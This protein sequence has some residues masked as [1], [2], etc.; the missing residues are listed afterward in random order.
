MD[1]NI[2]KAMQAFEI[3]SHRINYLFLLPS[4][5]VAKA[6]G[7]LSMK[8]IMSL[9]YNAVKLGLLGPQD[10]DKRDALRAPSDTSRDQKRAE[11]GPAGFA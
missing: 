3:P 5:Y 4:F 9:R 7:K 1:E 6:D 8:E 11:A 10:E 2:K